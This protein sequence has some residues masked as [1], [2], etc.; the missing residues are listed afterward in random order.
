MPN[1]EERYIMDLVHKYRDHL[2]GR[3]LELVRGT[4]VS[5]AGEERVP[6]KGL[7]VFSQVLEGCLLTVAYASKDGH[8]LGVLNW[9]STNPSLN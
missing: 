2:V 9:K 1:N 8:Q 7:T 6:I 5:Q 4:R 3:A